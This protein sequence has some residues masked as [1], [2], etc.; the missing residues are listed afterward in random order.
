MIDKL[1]VKKKLILE[2]TLELMY[3]SSYESVNIENVSNRSGLEV[4]KIKKIYPTDDI[5]KLS[6]MKYAAAIW[7]ELVKKD[8][9]KQ[10][11]KENKLYV[12]I[13]HF[14]AGSESHPESL[15]L[16]IDIWKKLRIL[17]YENSKYINIML[18]FFKK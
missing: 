10:D 9:K 16:Y 6:A 1:S 18:H 17:N 3:K 8:L 11:T 7:V 2:T 5:L 13:R 4:A 12:L 14:I 15:S